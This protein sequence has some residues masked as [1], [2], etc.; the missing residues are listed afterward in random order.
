M[1]II[2]VEISSDTE[3]HLHDLTALHPKLSISQVAGQLLE[4]QVQYRL[5]VERMKPPS[6]T[7]NNPP[8][9]AS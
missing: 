2:H 1:P 4:A 9:G 6:F 3:R 8:F 7:D 5:E